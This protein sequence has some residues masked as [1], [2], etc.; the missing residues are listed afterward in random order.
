M[1]VLDK[2]LKI[3]PGADYKSEDLDVQKL[4][5]TDAQHKT[6]TTHFK[7]TTTK[8]TEIEREQNS[9][10]ELTQQKDVIKEKKKSKGCMS[11]CFKRKKGKK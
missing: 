7:M 5:D 4:L 9:D 10:D 1:D 11:N 3:E 6:H 8:I 2:V